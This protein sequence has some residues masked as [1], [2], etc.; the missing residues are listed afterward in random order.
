MPKLSTSN[1][2]DLS[3]QSNF[4]LAQLR[5]SPLFCAMKKI[6]QSL[7]RPSG[8]A[9]SFISNTYAILRTVTKFG[10]STAMKI[11]D[12]Q[13]GPDAP[14]SLSPLSATLTKNRGRGLSG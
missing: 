14:V 4:A 10:K 3:N 13:D 9:K 11:N 2:F 6:A 1:Y 12:L 7:C 5:L 8:S